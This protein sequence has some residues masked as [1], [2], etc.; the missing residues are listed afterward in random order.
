M[1]TGP[2]SYIEPALLSAADFLQNTPFSTPPYRAVHA[3]LP[4]S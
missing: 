3:R 4:R 1:P 2:C